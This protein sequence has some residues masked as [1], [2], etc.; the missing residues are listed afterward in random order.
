MIE[1]LS[2]D[3]FKYY[4]S[5]LP[6]DIPLAELVRLA[7]QRWAI[8]QGYQQSK[9]EPGFDHFEGCSWRGLHH[10]LTLC[11]LAFCLLTKLRSSK[12]TTLAA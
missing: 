7:H 5:S 12:K 2:E 10:H 6:V 9:E 8:E 3:T 1:Q 11:F 4:L